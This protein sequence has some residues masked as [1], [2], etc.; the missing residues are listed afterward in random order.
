MWSGR[1]FKREQS[2]ICL[3]EKY[4]YSNK[5]KQIIYIRRESEIESEIERESGN[6]SESGNERET[7]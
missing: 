1:E 2:R 3:S 6:E 5:Q 7:A 4:S